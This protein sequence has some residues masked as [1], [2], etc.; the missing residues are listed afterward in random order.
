MNLVLLLLGFRV[1]AGSPVEIATRVFCAVSLFSLEM[2]LTTWMGIA[3]L[4]SLAVFNVLLAGSLYVWG[5][6]TRAQSDE[7]GL[8]FLQVPTIRTLNP[9]SYLGALVLILNAAL[10]LTAADPYHLMR[11]ERIQRLGTIAYDP[12][13]DP[14]LNVLGFLYELLLADLRVIP[15]IGDVVVKFHGIFELLLFAVT[16]ASVLQILGT[17]AS[18]T[19]DPAC[20][21]MTSS[22]LVWMMG[23]AVPVVFHQFVLLKNDLFGAVPAVLVLVWLIARIR[24]ASPVEVGWA[25]WLVGIAFGMK[26]TSFPLAL[27]TAAAILIW[28][29]ERRMLTAALVGVFI[30]L[31]SGGL[32][33]TLLENSRVYGSSVEPLRDLGNRNTSVP[34]ATVSVARFA[35]SLFDMGLLTRQWWP[36]RGGWGGTYGLPV[37]WA[38][39]VLLCARRRPEA[40]RTLTIATLYWLAFAAIYPDADI[41]HRLALAPGLLVV[42]IAALLAEQGLE[43]PRWLR[44][45]AIP[46]VALSALQIARS[47]A[48]YLTRA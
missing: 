24:V 40:R 27:I 47:A 33:F 15:L 38:L 7:T 36:G 12:A 1:W 46:V 14:K 10:P 41:A 31:L 23:C 18:T 8:S 4:R 13:A 32:L 3:T 22:R 25:A 26:L 6:R 43:V 39:G 20:A 5:R 34:E 29:C 11:A 37:I 42:I 48:L 45:A 16:I 19:Q 35:I 28:R 9:I 21:G 2:Q 30:G 17:A 44:A